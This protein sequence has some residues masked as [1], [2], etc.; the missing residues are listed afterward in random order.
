MTV[1]KSKSNCL[2]TPGRGVNHQ[3]IEPVLLWANVFLYKLK[4]MG[5]RSRVW[6]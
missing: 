5:N 3:F 6:G 1:I 2:I 4:T